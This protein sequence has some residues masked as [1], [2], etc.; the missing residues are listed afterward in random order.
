M[1]KGN[2]PSFNEFRKLCPIK[3]DKLAKSTEKVL[4][5]LAYWSPIFEDLDYLPQMVFPFGK[6]FAN[7][8]FACT[9]VL[10]S[11]IVN[12]C[13]GWFEF[14]PNPPIEVFFIKS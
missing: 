11:I 8:L 13:H 9:E 5:L 1:A 3:S 6:I 10:M 12:W 7:D 14:Y 2:H 4:S